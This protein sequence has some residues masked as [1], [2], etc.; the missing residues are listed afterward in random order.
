MKTVW[1]YAELAK[2]CLKRPESAGHSIDEINI[3]FQTKLW[4]AQLK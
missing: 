3:P 1:D 4:A 2:P